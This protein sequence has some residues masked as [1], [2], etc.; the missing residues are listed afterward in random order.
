MKYL[1]LDLFVH[2]KATETF[3]VFNFFDQTKEDSDNLTFLQTPPFGQSL[4]VGALICTTDYHKLINYEILMYLSG[5]LVCAHTGEI[6][7]F[8]SSHFLP[9]MCK[10]YE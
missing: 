7:P 4:V 5:F 9:D 2:K 8:A 10:R 6:V 3:L 1:Q